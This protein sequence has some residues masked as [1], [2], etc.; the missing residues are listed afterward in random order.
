M[1]GCNLWRNWDD[2]QCSAFL[3]PPCARPPPPFRVLPHSHNQLAP[4][5]TDWGSLSSII[6]HWGDWGSVLAPWAGPGHWHDPD[7]LLIGNGCIT[8]DEERTQMAIWSLVAGPLIMGNDLRTVPAASKAIL[9]NQ[10]AIA[11]NQ[12]PLGQQGLRLDNSSTAP[13]QVWYRVLANGDV[14]VGLYNKMGGGPPLPP[15]PGP[16]CAAWNHTPGGYYEACGGGAGDVG[17]FSGKTPAEAQAECC[18]NLQCAGFSFAGDGSGKGSGYYKG[19]LNCGFTPASGYE[20][21]A[22]PSQIP[23]S[24]AAPADITVTFA[25]IN[26]F[27]SVTVFDVWAQ[28]S[29]GA[30]TGSFTAK[31]VPFHGTALLR[32]SVGAQ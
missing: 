21:Y 15:I 32:L 26:L 23:S 7:M 18:A 2:I 24:H 5:P 19:N 4:N 25:D 27:G 28:Q 3:P 11:I 8:E 14:A 30:F 22:K 16:P 29:L 20:G 1:D 10:H 17:T 9:F 12:D 31:Q 6:D 13:T